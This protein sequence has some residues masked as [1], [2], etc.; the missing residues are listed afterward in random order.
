MVLLSR[1]GRVLRFCPNPPYLPL[2][3]ILIMRESFA[4]GIEHRLSGAG[5]FIKETA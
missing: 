2:S 1:Y 5:R 4:I 3:R